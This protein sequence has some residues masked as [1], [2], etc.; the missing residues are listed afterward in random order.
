MVPRKNKYKISAWSQNLRSVFDGS[1]NLIFAFLFG[2]TVSI[3][4]QT[5]LGNWICCPF[6]SVWLSGVEFFRVLIELSWHTLRQ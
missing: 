6:F 5:G 4:L 2:L 3:F 1:Q